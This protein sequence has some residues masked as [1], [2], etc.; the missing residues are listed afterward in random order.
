[1]RARLGI[2][3]TLVNAALTLAP[4][5]VGLVALAPGDF[6]RFSIVY[7]LFAW[8]A[9]LQLSIVCEPVARAGRDG[10]AQTR[11]HRAAGTW[12]ALPIGV[13][14]AAASQVA[15]GDVAL[16]ALSFVA[17]TAASFRI[18]TRYAALLDGEWRG[19]LRT[20]VVGAVF[21]VVACAAAALASLS[22]PAVVLTA[23][24]AAGVGV[25]LLGPRPVPSSP[26]ALTTWISS[27]KDEIKPLLKDSLVL[28]ASS[29]G[30][31][32][33]L[34][35]LLGFA[36]FGIYRALSNVAAPVRLVI[37]PLRPAWASMDATTLHRVLRRVSLVIALPMG[38]LAAVALV[39]VGELPWTLGVLSELSEWAVAAGA[40][41]AFSMVSHIYYIAARLHAPAVNLWRGRLVQSGTAMV[42]PLAGVL[43]DGLRGAMWAFVAATAIGA[44]VWVLQAP[45]RRSPEV[46]TG[47]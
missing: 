38:A 34:S 14:A 16:T 31:P 23:W 28:D 33:L 10:L 32:Y 35:P 37:E 6:G 27:R 45:R 46:H 8:G 7:L 24:A 4:Q 22:A 43:V 40:F 11:E 13:L 36:S 26:T 12:V 5:L 1:M 9:S 20:D 3:A 17:V 42:L 2:V 19:V 18:A 21:F 30:T 44:L 29:I 15:W 41:V 25:T 47:S 39:V